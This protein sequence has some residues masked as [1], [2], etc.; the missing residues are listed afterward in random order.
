MKNKLISI[1]LSL[2]ILIAGSR[3]LE[4]IINDPESSVDIAIATIIAYGAAYIIP[5]LLIFFHNGRVLQDKSFLKV[6]SDQLYPMMTAMSLFIL[7][8]VIF[9]FL[10]KPQ[11]SELILLA[12]L[13][14]V[15]FILISSLIVSAIVIG[16]KKD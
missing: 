4:S 1:I 2:G 8:Q 13:V 6:F 12:F 7:Y 5:R 15:I 11:L 14:Q 3:F 10:N 9:K 16:L